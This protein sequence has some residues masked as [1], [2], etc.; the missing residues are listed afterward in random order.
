MV[1]NQR[2]LLALWCAVALAVGNGA[3]LANAA[4][5]LVIGGGVAGLKAALDL[6]KNGYD[7]TVLEVSTVV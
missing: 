6:A 2:A 1:V 3:V 7:V 5:A 4:R